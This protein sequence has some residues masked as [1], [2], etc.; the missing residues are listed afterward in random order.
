MCEATSGV[1]RGAAPR[2]TYDGWRIYAPVCRDIPR[3]TRMYPDGPIHDNGI[4]WSDWD[5]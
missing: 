5:L 1:C 3:Y 2:S 4:S